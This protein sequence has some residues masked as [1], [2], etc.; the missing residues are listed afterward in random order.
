MGSVITKSGEH[1]YQTYARL[2]QDSILT[3]VLLLV[4]RQPLLG[5]SKIKII[6]YNCEDDISQK[7]LSV[8]ASIMPELI[9]SCWLQGGSTD[10]TSAFASLDGFCPHFAHVCCTQMRS[11]VSNHYHPYTLLPP[12]WPHSPL[13][14]HS[15]ALLDGVYINFLYLCFVH[16]CN[17]QSVLTPHHPQVVPLPRIRPP[18]VPTLLDRFWPKCKG[19]S[20]FLLGLFLSHDTAH[21]QPHK[22][23]NTMGR[24]F[25][26]AL[27]IR[28]AAMCF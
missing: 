2:S 25:I 5:S 7:A 22:N 4:P 24:I 1:I 6:Y 13:Y 8:S 18:V 10:P 17:C 27:I 26:L 20:E 14:D 15:I 9:S 12:R 19:L 21:I 28:Q 11:S 3:P 16:T 23:F